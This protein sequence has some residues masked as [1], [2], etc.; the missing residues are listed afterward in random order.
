MEGRGPG[1]RESFRG[2]F[3]LGLR[4]RKGGGPEQ[5]AVGGHDAKRRKENPESSVHKSF[6]LAQIRKFG[7]QGRQR[8][9]GIVG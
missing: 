4:A 2:L 5:Q 3:L 7:E 8:A 6:L 1:R 9:A